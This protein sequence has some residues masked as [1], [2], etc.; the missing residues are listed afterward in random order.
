M[1][2]PTTLEAAHGRW[3]EIAPM[4]VSQ[5]LLDGKHHP[6]PA[7]G[8]KDRFRFHDK[9][10]DG[11]YYCHGCGAG[12]GISLVS[13]VNG[14]TYAEAAKRVDEI[15]GNLPATAR[16]WQKPQRRD[17]RA[18][19]ERLWLMSGPVENNSPVARYFEMRGGLDWSCSDLR[20][21]PEM[22]HTGTKSNHPGMLALVRNVDGNGTPMLHRT[23]L[24]IDGKKADVDP[25]RKL[26]PGEFPTGGAIRL[27]GTAKVM[28]VAEGIETALAA[29]KLYGMP[30]WSTVAEGF[31]QTWEPPA[32]AEHVFIFADNDANFVGQHA[33]YALAKR[34]IRDYALE[35]EVRIPAGIGVD[36]NDVLLN[37]GD[38]GYAKAA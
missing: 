22:Y 31:L 30:V 12:K 17:P 3:R 37:G 33:A 23:Y 19:A 9:N 28:G 8:G 1:N 16:P 21:V 29:S 18:A 14:L 36:W 34:L 25:C 15:I 2:K 13:K 24:T 20:Y 38:H 26:I 10:G 32:A 35:I 5:K 6:C 7:C 4:F 27:G 11:D